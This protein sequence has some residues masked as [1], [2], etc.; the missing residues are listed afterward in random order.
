M[1]MLCDPADSTLL[2]IDHAGAA[3]AVDPRC[4]DRDPALRPARHGGARA[5]HPRHRHRGE[6]RRP[7]PA[8][9]RGRGALRHHR[10]PSS[11]SRRPPR[12]ASCRACRKGRNTFVVAGCEAHVCV[13]QTVAGLL[14]AGHAVKWVADAV[15]SRHPHNRLAATERARRP[16]RRHRDDRD[17]DLRVAAAPASIRS[18]GS[19]CSWSADAAGRPSAAGRD[20]DPAP[21]PSGHQRLG[22][23][24]RALER[25]LLGHQL[26]RAADR[27]RGPAAPRRCGA[28]RSAPSRCRCRRASRRAG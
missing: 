19:C 22:L 1:S 28:A 11:T 23:G 3:D 20:D 12:T 6:P 10:S 26:E 24:D 2:I 15:G 13:M 18:S 25:H 4:R 14:D 21:H 7:G 5:R 9:A 8:G 27:G 17:G 16:G